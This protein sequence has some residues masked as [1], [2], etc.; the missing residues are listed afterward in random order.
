[1]P[2]SHQHHLRTVMCTKHRTGNLSSSTFEGHFHVLFE[3]PDWPPTYTPEH[4]NF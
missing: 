2:Q 1:M 3:K 4:Q